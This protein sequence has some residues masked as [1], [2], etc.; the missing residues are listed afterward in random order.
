MA[1]EQILVVEDQRAVAG[2]LRMRLR[3]LGYDVTAIAKDG[4]EAIEKANELQPDLILMDIRL[5]D[6]MDGIEAA[7]RIRSH[8]N[9]PVIYISAHVDQKLLDRA[10]ATQPAGFINKPFTTKDLL[11]AIDFALHRGNGNISLP[12]L[13]AESQPHERSRDAVVTTDIEGRI[14][15]VNRAAERVIGWQRKQLLGRSLVEVIAPL[16]NLAIPDAQKIFDQVLLRGEE[17]ALSRPLG[18]R[19]P[20]AQKEA[21]VITP[22]FDSRGQS[23]GVALRFGQDAKEPSNTDVKHIEKAY[24]RAME[25][26]PIG[27]LIVS[28]DMRVH[29]M[30]RCAR[31]LM[32]RTRS[33]DFRNQHLQAQD[34][35][36]DEKLRSL[37]GAA[38]DKAEKGIQDETGAIFI[39]GAASGDQIEILVTPVANVGGGDTEPCVVLYLFDA[40]GHRRISYDMLTQLYGLTQTEAKLVQL[41]T[42][43]MTLDEAAEELEIS[44]NTVR[45]H[46]KHIFHKIGIN[47]QSDLIHRIETGAAA[48]LLQFDSEHRLPVS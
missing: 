23:Y 44:V 25:A 9:I 35:Q 6:G 12:E 40:N 34:R 30:N 19:A 15:F 22:L 17:Q 28:R 32:Q 26:I 4:I 45:T 10:R 11:T 5:G 8:S 47:R 33:L 24:S 31:E 14:T 7:Q 48:L 41:L 16:Y 1:G 27:I 29:H 18:S 3:G 13:P 39:K 43:G 36:I 46:L 20:D 37:I 21:D 2:A 38:A 42:N